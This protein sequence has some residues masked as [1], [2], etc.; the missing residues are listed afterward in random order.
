MPPGS[1]DSL[2]LLNPTII[3]S[4]VETDEQYEGCMSFFDVRCRIPR[5]LTIHVEHFDLDGT[6]RVTVFDH[7]M[8]RLVSHEIVH[9]KG[10][11]C[12]DLLPPGR[13][14][15]PVDQCRGTGSNWQ[16]GWTGSDGSDND[17]D[18]RRNAPV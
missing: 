5:P 14:P 6:P 4:S 15:T 7:G 9:L 17:H 3:D 8:A 13:Q 11:L 1:T 10:I 18:S 2:V 16:Y 12:C